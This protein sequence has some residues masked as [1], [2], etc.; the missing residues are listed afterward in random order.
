MKKLVMTG[1][2]LVCAASVALAQTVT[3]AN[4]VGYNKGENT[5]FQILGTQFDTGDSTPA[6]VFG[7]QLPLGSKV[8]TF[9]GSYQISTYT[10]GFF[11]APNFWSVESDIGGG[12]GYWLAVPEGTHTSIVSGEVP[13][14]DSITNSIVAGFQM[15]SYPY[16]VERNVTQLGLAPQIGDK[17]YKFTDAYEIS[18]YTKGFFGAPDFWS[19]D[20]LLGVGEGFWYDSGV[21]TSWVVTRPFTP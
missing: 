12:V 6:G 10:E 21:D 20:F 2:V 7:D 4:M 14:D 15:M 3:S 9:D 17:I 1:A 8:Y 19:S 13:L 5:S 18:T 16:P 11:G